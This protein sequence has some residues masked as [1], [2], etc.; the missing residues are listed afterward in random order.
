MDKDIKMTP[1]AWDCLAESII[2]LREGKIKK[3]LTLDD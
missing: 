2:L 1:M 3:P